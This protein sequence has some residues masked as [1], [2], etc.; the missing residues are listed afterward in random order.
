M[1]PTGND[2]N[3]N[4]NCKGASLLQFARAFRD[5]LLETIEVVNAPVEILPSKTSVSVGCENLRENSI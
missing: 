4:F 1:Q 5:A 2:G 3:P